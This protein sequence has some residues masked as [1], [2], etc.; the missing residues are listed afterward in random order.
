L[1]VIVLMFIVSF[2]LAIPHDM[3]IDGK[4][5]D[6]SAFLLINKYGMS[7][8]YLVIF[9][10][11]INIFAILTSFLSILAGMKNSLNGI[12]F[13][14]IRKTNINATDIKIVD[15][16]SVLAIFLLAW[17]A[18]VFNP[19]IYKLVPLC[20]PIFGILGCLIPVYLVY[21]V[22][23]LHKLKTKSLYY[24]LFVGIVLIIS[25]LLSSSL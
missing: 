24:I 10:G 9:G 5:S 3:A 22:P 14:I 21:K 11:A 25:P 1:S 19:S 16:I 18:I 6:L 7:N 20:G 2:T 13:A 15:K 23:A 17:S 8:I 4:D 12:M